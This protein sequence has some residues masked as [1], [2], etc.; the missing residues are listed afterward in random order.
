LL[1]WEAAR[2]SS[3]APTYFPPF[4]H[5]K[6]RA[7]LFD[8]GLFANNP[9]GVALEESLK[10][11]PNQRQIDILLSIGNGICTEKPKLSTLTPICEHVNTLAAMQNMLLTNIDS[12]KIWHDCFGNLQSG[13]PLGSSRYLRMNLRMEDQV[14]LNDTKAFDKLLKETERYLATLEAQ[15]LMNNI[16]YRL[17]ATSFYLEPLRIETQHNGM[18]RLIGKML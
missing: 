4:F 5:S 13:T 6:I 2:A 16:I 10:I 8:G 12:E 9:A 14:K 17:I 1:L 11:W 7:H 3:A 18:L 15:H